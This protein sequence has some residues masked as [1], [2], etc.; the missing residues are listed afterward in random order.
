MK[1]H[2]KHITYKEW[3][4]CDHKDKCL[5]KCAFLPLYNKTWNTIVVLLWI[6]VKPYLV[7][8]EWNGSMTPLF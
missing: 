7:E 1:L 3:D 5:K 8:L 4:K 2:A 6:Y